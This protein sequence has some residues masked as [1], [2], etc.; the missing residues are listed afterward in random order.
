MDAVHLVGAED[1]RSAGQ[2]MRHA[3]EDMRSA[4]NTIS[5]AMDQ[6][7]RFMDEWMTRFEV[8]MARPDLRCPAC[9]S[10]D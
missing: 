8:A 3:A 10:D 4:A 2:S 6:Q 5:E 1:V 9:K 7:R